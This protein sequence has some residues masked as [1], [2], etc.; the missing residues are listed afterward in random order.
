MASWV[1]TVFFW[2]LRMWF[3]TCL[4]SIETIYVN[5]ILLDLSSIIYRIN[6]RMFLHICFGS[7]CTTKRF[8]NGKKSLL[9]AE[10]SMAVQLSRRIYMSV[11]YTSS[12]HTWVHR[13][14]V[15]QHC[16]C[17][18]SLPLVV[19]DMLWSLDLHGVG[20]LYDVL[21]VQRGKVLVLPLLSFDPCSKMPFSMCLC[22]VQT[23]HFDSKTKWQIFLYEQLSKDNAYSLDMMSTLDILRTHSRQ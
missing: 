1:K 3:F 14:W 5:E 6:Y 16:S 9:G 4:S 20:G 21:V 23:V 18:N 10:K 2:V 15:F 13:V 19:K 7:C 11:Q 8:H 12:N 17:C 22:Q